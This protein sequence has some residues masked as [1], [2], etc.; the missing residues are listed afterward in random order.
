MTCLR[1]LDAIPPN[2]VESSSGDEEEEEEDGP[3]FWDCDLE[4]VESL[5]SRSSTSNLSRSATSLG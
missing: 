2:V 3:L 5:P 1:S 4:D